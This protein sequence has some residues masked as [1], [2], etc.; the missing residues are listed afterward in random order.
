VIER[1]LITA[2]GGV[3]DLERALP[4]GTAGAPAVATADAGAT[5]VLSARRLRQLERDNMIAALDRAQW[6]V[7]GDRGAAQ[8]LGISPSTFKSRM[9]ALKIIRRPA[10]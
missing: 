2:T 4:L 10:T 7:A 1:A 5:E 6:H 3:V 9:K 8:Q